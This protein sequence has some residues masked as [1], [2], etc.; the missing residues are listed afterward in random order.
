MQL[1]VWVSLLVKYEECADCLDW[2]VGKHGIFI[3]F[4]VDSKNYNATYL[5]EVAYAQ[6]WTKK[7]CI[8]S[9]V[10]KAGYQK[11]M[12]NEFLAGIKCTR[13]QSSKQELTYARYVILNRRDPVQEALHARKLKSKQ[14]GL[15]SW[16]NL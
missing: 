8:E 14:G 10:R 12:S 2:E 6:G 15:R 13:Y 9:L 7:E 5:P 11:N 16:L 3:T 1:K 4:L